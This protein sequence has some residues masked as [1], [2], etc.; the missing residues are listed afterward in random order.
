MKTLKNTSEIIQNIDIRFSY[1]IISQLAF[2]F[3][4]LSLK[5][6]IREKSI[7]RNKFD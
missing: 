5:N 6:N 3:L 2:R 4:N 1:S 7:F